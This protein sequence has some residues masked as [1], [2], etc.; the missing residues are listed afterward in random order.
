MAGSLQAKHG[1][2]MQ[3]AYDVPPGQEPQFNM[4]CTFNKALDESAFLVSIPMV[5]GKL[6]IPEETQKLLFRY[7]EG[8]GQSLVA[9]YVDDVVKEGIRRYWKVRRVTEQ[10]QFVQRRDIRLKIQIP[11]TYMQDTWELNSEGQIEKETGE[12]MDI[13]NNGMAVCMNHWFQVGESCIFTLPRLGNAGE[14]QEARDAVGVIC[15]MREL[16]KGGPFRFAAGI[17]L[18]FSSTEESREMQD[19]VAYVKQR[20]KL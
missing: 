2:K 16:P 11:V 17:Q 7:G 14:G 18:R 12:T 4:I 5:D 1:A 9:G 13:S 10:R 15:W 3:L 20:Y 6:L 19:Y 8:D